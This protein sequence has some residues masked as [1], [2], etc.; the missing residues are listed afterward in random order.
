MTCHAG[1]LRPPRRNAF[2]TLGR[3]I[4]PDGGRRTHWAKTRY[5]CRRSALCPHK[6]EGASMRKQDHKR[7]PISSQDGQKPKPA[8]TEV[9]DQQLEEAAGG[10]PQMQDI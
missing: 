9:S 4:E 7:E 6:A 8:S 3:H 10:K 1:A 2:S 5:D